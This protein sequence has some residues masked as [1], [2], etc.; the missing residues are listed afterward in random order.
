MLAMSGMLI[1]LANLEKMWPNL[2]KKWPNFSKI[3]FSAGNLP[4]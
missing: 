1:K 4:L 3:P 2:E